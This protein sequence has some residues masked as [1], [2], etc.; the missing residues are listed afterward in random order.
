MS[1][2]DDAILLCRV[3]DEK[4][5]DGYSLEAQ[6]RVGRDYCK[7]NGFN[8]L[9][10][11]R[12][13]ETGSKSHDRK[14][15]DRMMGFIGEY[16]LKSSRPLHLIVEK[17]DRLTRN[18]TNREQLQFYVMSGKLVI[19]YYKDR[20]VL[21]KNCSPAD[22]FTDDIM[23]SVSKYIALNI[24]REV[25]KG[26]NE[27]A[28]NGWFPG[29]AP[30]GYKNIREGAENK[31][32]RQEAKIVIDD[33]TKKAVLRIFELRALK[34]F[35]YYAIRDE[36]LIE[37]ILPEKQARR[38][39]KS[40]VESVLNNPFYEGRFFWDEEWHQGK[41]EL[42]VPMEW[43]R[44]V[45]GQRGI[46]NTNTFVGPFSYLITCAVPGCGCTVIYD[47]KTKVNKTD[48]KTR[49]Y[50]YYHCADGKRFHKENS[51]RQVN[52]SEKQLWESFFQPIR[53]LSLDE[54]MAQFLMNHIAEAGRQAK[55]SADDVK[56]KARNRLAEM[57]RKEDELYEHWSS[58]LLSKDAYTRHL[59]RFK[60]ERQEIEDK[61][62]TLENAK[63]ETIEEKAKTLLE[64][65]KRA[66]SAWNKGCT[67]ERIG[68]VKRVCSNFRL[69]GATLCYDLKNPFRKLLELKKNTDNSKWWA[70]EDLNL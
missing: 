46:P 44:K 54:S 62:D 61:L 20:R 31:H 40:T 66:E 35:S 4:Q 1:K 26:M 65:C 17:P 58:G 14:K 50:H 19:H 10:L 25:R 7:K 12:M 55:E 52:V 27:K 57:T 23:T 56:K 39:S 42:F 9:D 16:V 13:V 63:D 64:L 38:F 24:A 29:H 36:I 21:D 51:I 69:D 6:E 47:P 18:F 70:R 41:H 22:I 33:S 68:L 45:N 32:G 3:S 49:V 8:I 48:G 60:E 15:F 53:D 43:I 5:K 11:F 28:R 37:D 34:G 2:I 30:L 59:A 67:E